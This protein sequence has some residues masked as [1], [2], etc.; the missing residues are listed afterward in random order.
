MKI[1]N[2]ITLFIVFVAI[3]ASCESDKDLLYSFDY[4]PAP[5]KVSAVFDITQDNTGLVSI[6]PNAEGAQKFVISFG[7]GSEPAEYNSG[8]IATHT[9]N[10]GVYTVSITAV[11][12]TGL[13]SALNQQLTVSF[14]APENLNVSIENN[15]QNPKIVTVSAT[16]DFATVIEI[17]FGDVEDEEPVLALPG[18]VVTHT[19]EEAGDYEVRIIAKSAGAA[20]TEYVQTVVVPEASDPV[21]LPVSFES[22]TVNYAFVNFGGANSSVIDNPDK[23]G[24]NT[25]ERVAQTHKTS[26]AETWAGSFLTLQNPINFSTNTLF[27]VNVWSPKVGATVKLKVENLTDGNIGFEIDALTSV[28]G[29][30]EEL[31]FDFSAINK[32]QSYQ[33]VVIFFDFGNVGD[34]S[35]YYFDDIKLVAPPTGFSPLA[36]TWKIAP[37]AGAIGVGPN[38]GDVSWWANSGDDVTARACYFDDTYVFGLDGT[39]RNVLGAETW[40]EG[41]Q[42]GTDACGAPVAPHDGTVIATY[43]HDQAAGTFTLN[44]KGAY[45][46]LAKVFN[47]GELTNPANAPNSITYEVTLADDN[48]SM[49]LDISIGG[50]WW[51]FKLVKESGAVVSPLAGTWQMAPI[52]GALGVGPGLGDI[53]WWAN[54]AADVAG[55]ACFFDDTYVFRADGSFSN[56]LGSETWVEGWQ[57]GSDACGAPVA[58]HDGSANAT[59]TWDATAG[60]VT[61]TGKGAYLGIPKAF[62]GGELAN[63][64]NAPDSITYN[65]TLS[66][67]NTAMTLD[68]SIG[69][70][71]WRFKLVK[72]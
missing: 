30:W 41:W 31:S 13:T 72:I 56:V 12:I 44:G 48:N 52:A 10:E 43:S 29:Q 53:S 26:G 49:I 8:A 6:V 20:T 27:K 24:I 64:A 68:I 37:E 2:K 50:G 57:G 42:G 63:P 33:K 47:G 62:N 18:E 32:D 36:G 7:D 17:Y 69:G 28:A 39:F 59:Y 22:F 4:I 46:G 25:S 38:K 70:G 34:N 61:L 51:R 15:V 9:Y 35:M 40:I 54:S 60:T 71:W 19:Y 1:F 3:I 5:A 21:V 55:R 16:A 45:I 65:I 23:S 14:K 67:D 11:G 66:D 58:P